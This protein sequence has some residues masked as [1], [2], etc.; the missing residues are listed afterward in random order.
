VGDLDHYQAYRAF[1]R[2]IA[3]YEQLFSITPSHIAHDMHPDYASTQFAISQ[4][5][6]CIP[7]QHHHAHIASCMAEHGLMEKVIG[8]AFDGSG[9]GTDGTIWGG[10]FLV[11]DY[12]GFERAGHLLAVPLPGGEQAVRQPWRMAAS[13]LAA[14][15]A[16]CGP[17]ERRQS[18]PALRTVQQ[19]IEKNLHA[20]LTSSMG[21]LFDAVASLCGVRDTVSYEGQAAVELQAL[22]TPIEPTGS[23]PFRVSG[24]LQVGTRPT[25]RAIADDV[26]NGVDPARIA[27]KFHSTVVD[28]IAAV[29]RRLHYATKIHTVVLSGGVF[30]NALLSL[31]TET[32]LRGEGFTVFRHETVPCNDGGLCL[33]QLAIAARAIQT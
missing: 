17:F 14:A 32:R 30:M 33:G 13:Y 25:I 28:M 15:H 1:E 8:V 21:R 26:N 9:F 2:D 7:I 24:A 11:A 4:N 10:E 27:R 18:A 12:T 19:M 6:P 16:E 3:L 29:C 31:E 23:Y 22:A 5:I 20:P